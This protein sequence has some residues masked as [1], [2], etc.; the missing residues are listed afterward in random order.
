MQSELRGSAQT[1]PTERERERRFQFA[2]PPPIP[3]A[4]LLTGHGCTWQTE[5]ELHLVLSVC[6]CVSRRGPA[7]LPPAPF[8]YFQGFPWRLLAALPW[9]GV[10]PG[11]LAQ[12]HSARSHDPLP[13]RAATNGEGRRCDGDRGTSRDRWEGIRRQELAGFIWDGVFWF[14]FASGLR[15]EERRTA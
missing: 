4:G 12:T 9:N 13:A 2:S 10:P 6:V 7:R 11:G 3:R 5:T 1:A 8:L 14:F 15:S